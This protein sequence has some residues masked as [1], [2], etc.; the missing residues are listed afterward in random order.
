MNLTPMRFKTFVWP[1][2]PKIY[3]I[4]FKR[5]LYSHKV[6]F[7]RYVLQNLGM[8]YRILRGEGEFC[9]EMAYEQFRALGTLFYDETPGILVHPIWQADNV[10]LVSL[11]L[12]EE[13]REDYVSYTFEFWECFDNYDSNATLITVEEESPESGSGSDEVWYTVV[14]G[15]CL[16][17]IALRNS[18]TLSELLAINP[19]IK[20]PNILYPGD[21]VRVS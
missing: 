11:A 16:W 8:S 6:P 20:N 15:D 1:H 14:Y 2:N 21:L 4:E 17:N 3:E 13:P 12:R 10:Y 18:L 19:Q 5:S 9:G 7:G